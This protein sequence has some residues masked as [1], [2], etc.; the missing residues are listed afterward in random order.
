[1]TD[2]VLVDGQRLFSDAL[3][4]VLTQEGFTVRAVVDR[5][6]GIAGALRRTRPEVV[7]LERHFGEGDGIDLIGDIVAC[8]PGAKVMVLTAVHDGDG[9]RRALRSGAAGY[10][11]TTC[12]V[13]ALSAAIRRVVAG[14]IVV[15]VGNRHY[16][17]LAATEAHRLAAQLTA[18]ERQCLMLLVDGMSTTAMVERLGVSRT[19]VRT[20]VQA[21]LTKLGV[22]S[23]LE[24]ASFAVRHSL[25]AR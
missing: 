24:A 22:H 18:R 4:V 21:L 2:L 9:L 13:R 19:T 6:A 5:R 12:G 1:M 23:R 10:L 16:P 11:E 17:D 7:L 8:A 20:H 15:E 14:E 25:L 3:V